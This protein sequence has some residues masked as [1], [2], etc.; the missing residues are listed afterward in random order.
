VTISTGIISTY[1]GT[2]VGSSSGDGG[3][4]T[5][6]YLYWPNGLGIDSAGNPSFFSLTMSSYTSFC[7]QSLYR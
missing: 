4:A 3:A 2:G 5:S 6:G 1:A 7:R